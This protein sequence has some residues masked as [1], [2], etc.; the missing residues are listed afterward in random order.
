MKTCTKCEK[1]KTLDSFYEN[2]TVC[3]ECIKQYYIDNKDKITKRNKL[4]Y[5][6]N[7]KIINRRSKQWKT[8]N[9]EK[10]KEYRIQY[11]K[12]NIEK[13]KKYTKQWYIDNKKIINRRSKQ[14]K[15]DNPE[16]K[17]MYDIITK[18]L[19][20]NQIPDLTKEE[21]DRVNR[22]YKIRD[23]LNHNGIDF[24]VDH[25]QPLSKGGLHHPDNLQILPSLLNLEKHSKWPLTESE[26]IK[27][28][29]LKI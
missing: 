18:D 15:T 9:P 25:I 5:E 7:K 19:K 8:D 4:Y 3:K 11:R 28:R 27:Y 16:R 14:W 1:E 6:D 10:I 13:I 29:G 20:P 21:R 24:H 2:K 17:A 22:L 23:L 12:D 26:Q